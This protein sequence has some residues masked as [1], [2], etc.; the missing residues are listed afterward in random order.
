MWNKPREL[1]AYTDNGYE[2]AYGIFGKHT[3][4]ADSAFNAWKKSRNHNAIILNKKIWKSHHWNA[5]GVGIY[6]N[7][8]LIWFG[9]DE[10][11]GPMPNN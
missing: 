7:H 8:A 5:L 9:E 10:D 4:T 2:I 1:T 11:K 3:A 6:K